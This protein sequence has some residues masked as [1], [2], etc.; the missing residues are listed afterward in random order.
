MGDI[1]LPATAGNNVLSYQKPSQVFNSASSQGSD[2]NKSSLANDPIDFF[3]PASTNN[4]L[5]DLHRLQET[6]SKSVATINKAQQGISIIETLVDYA[7]ELARSAMALQGETSQQQSTVKNLSGNETLEE[8][9]NLD[10][11]D[12]ITIGDGLHSITATADGS[13][14]I[15][16]FIEAIN[17]D[18]NLD[19]KASLYI[20]SLQLE[21]TY[22]N[23]ITASINDVAG[24]ANTLSDIG[25]QDIGDD[26]ISAPGKLSLNKIG[27]SN[28]YNQILSIIDTVS[29]SAE[30]D[31]VNLLDGGSL[32]EKFNTNNIPTISIQGVNFDATSLGLTKANNKFQTSVDT[33]QAINEL[34]TASITLQNQSAKFFADKTKINI[35]ES[36]NKSLIYTLETGTNLNIKTVD[37]RFAEQLAQKTKQIVSSNDTSLTTATNTQALKVF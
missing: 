21:S 4:H 9:F 1:S 25:F 11:G 8:A 20:G 14:N 27:I 29:Q 17:S 34:Q 23:G 6:A 16:R 33:R 22:Y 19:V 7:Q 5:F 2:N 3:A 36:F 31:G 24:N 26:L 37:Q 13:L 28:T 18:D 30:H 32:I 12:Q 10:T 35:N 15:Q